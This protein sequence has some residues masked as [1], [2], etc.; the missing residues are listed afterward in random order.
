MSIL[1]LKQEPSINLI[2]EVD[3]LVY[4][5]AIVKKSIWRH[6]PAMDRLITT[7]FG[8]LK[9]N[10]VTKTTYRSKSKSELKFQYGGRPFFETG[11]SFTP[12][13]DWDIQ[14]KFG[15]QIDFHILQRMQS[16]IYVLQEIY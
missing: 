9:Q 11:S 1:S 6:N 10:H 15:T 2:P 16:L 12:A 14:S 7:K 8:R 3:F 5:A 13:V 4:G